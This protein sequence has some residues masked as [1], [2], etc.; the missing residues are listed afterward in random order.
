[1]PSRGVW[2]SAAGPG[3]PRSALPVT[4]A[5]SG[6]PA[7]LRMARSPSTAAPGSRNPPSHANRVPSPIERASSEQDPAGPAVCPALHPSVLGR[8]G[9][10]RGPR[11]AGGGPAGWRG[12]WG[13][14]GSRPRRGCRPGPRR[15]WP[16]RVL[17]GGSSR[18]RGA[19]PGGRARV[20]RVPALPRGAR[21]PSAGAHAKGRASAAPPTAS[22]KR[23]HD[24]DGKARVVCLL[25]QPPA[26]LPG[27][28]PATARRNVRPR[29]PREGLLPCRSRPLARA[30]AKSRS[31]ITDRPAPRP[32][33]D[34]DDG[35]DRGPQPPVPRR[36][37]PPGQ[38]QPHRERGPER[39]S[40]RVPRPRPR[41]PRV[42]VH[43]HDRVLPA[44]LQRRD[45]RGAVFHDP[46]RGTTAPKPGPA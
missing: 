42:H 34:G 9:C 27:A 39:R 23:D 37:G 30:S 5:G 19:R 43:G 20:A 24:D 10:P 17:R 8:P 29:F 32:P 4:R 6:C 21:S 44:F 33:G 26:E 1:M 15:G 11:S 12:A 40:R 18:S 38:L 13:G 35:A 16:C 3:I 45:R 25:H 7:N 14:G 2:P 22:C 36:G 31:S 28:M 41:V 46:R